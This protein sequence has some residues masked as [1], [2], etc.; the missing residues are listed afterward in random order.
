ML[1]V[2]IVPNRALRSLLENHPA[3]GSILEQA[4]PSIFWTLPSG[5]HREVREGDLTCKLK[6]L[7]ELADNN[8]LVCG[9]SFS[10]P[11][12]ASTLALIGIGPLADAGL[13][14]EAP[15]MMTNAPCDE[16]LISGF[17][18][19]EGW[20]EGITTHQEEV[21]LGGAFAA[22]IVCAVQSSERIEDFDDLFDERYSRSLYVRK[23][24]AG[25]W[26][27]SQ[28]LGKPYALYRLRIAPDDPYSLLTIQVMADAEGKCGAAQLVHA[29]NV[30]SGYEESLGIG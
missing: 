23:H 19:T 3:I 6:G 8:P 10:V 16:E 28:V 29:F 17:L 30:M 1:N 27:V 12:S 4:G 20:A 11:D 26:H 15:T 21:D 14:V 5:W 2:T 13:L 22:T 18:R 25:E 24:E 9:N 7:V